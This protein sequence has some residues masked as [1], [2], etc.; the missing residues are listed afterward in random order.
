[1]YAAFLFRPPSRHGITIWFLPLGIA[2]LV[3]ALLDLT[4]HNATSWLCIG[5]AHSLVGGAEVL[6]ATHRMASGVLRLVGVIAA[7]AALG[8]VVMT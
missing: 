7:L 4:A 5:L 2:I 6:P 8:L 3:L 1:M